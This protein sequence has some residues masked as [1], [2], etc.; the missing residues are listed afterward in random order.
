MPELF[1]DSIVTRHAYGPDSAT[2]FVGLTLLVA[3]LSWVGGT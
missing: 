3:Y 2:A 1:G